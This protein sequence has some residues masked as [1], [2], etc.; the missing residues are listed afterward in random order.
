MSES[1][2]R[3]IFNPEGLVALAISTSSAATCSGHHSCVLLP[4]SYGECGQLRLLG[5]RRLETGGISREKPEHMPASARSSANDLSDRLK[6]LGIGVRAGD[7]RL[8][9]GDDLLLLPVANPRLAE[10]SVDLILAHLCA[11]GKK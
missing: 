6:L 1:Q 9:D 3:H 8:D 5:W 7:G 2:F 4:G 10:Q 11:C